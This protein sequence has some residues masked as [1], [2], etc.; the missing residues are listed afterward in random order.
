MV[1]ERREAANTA[2]ADQVTESV[3]APSA[4]GPASTRVAD[5]RRIWEGKRFPR[6][7]E[8]R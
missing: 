2:V 6:A 3:Y 4:A 7:W 1:S 5:P 8:P